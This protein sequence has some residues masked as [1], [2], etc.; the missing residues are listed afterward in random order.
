MKLV[1]TGALGHIGS[2]LIREISEVYKTAEVTLL[3]DL[4]IQRYC[5]LFRLPDGIQWKF[6]EADITKADLEPHIKGADA[7]IHLAA[8]TNAA[9]SFEIRNRVFEVNL[10]GTERVAMACLNVGVP[11]VFPSTTS[12]YGSQAEIVDETC[13][14][15]GLKPQSPYAESKLQAEDLL[16]KLGKERGLNFVTCRLGTIFGTSIGMRFHTAINKFCWQ[17]TVGQPITVWK[18]ALNQNRPYLDLKDAV[19]AMSFILKNKIFDQEI[20]NVVS[21]NASV[22]EIL[23]VISRTIPE[24]KIDYVDAKIMNQLS[25]HVRSNKFESRGFNFTGDLSKGVAETLELLKGIRVSK[26]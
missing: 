20:Y 12:V 14:K 17:A 2:A 18:T 25:Y 1:I 7:V 13:T 24:I 9:D 21:T 19:R 5:S 15:E 26:A 23:D 16:T 10:T 6:V 4:S 8:I 22:K 3:D 11:L